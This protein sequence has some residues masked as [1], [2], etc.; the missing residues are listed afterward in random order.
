[1]KKYASLICLLIILSSSISGKNWIGLGVGAGMQ[2]NSEDVKEIY[3]STAFFPYVRMEISLSILK[4]HGLLSRMIF[5][6]DYM[7]A[8]KKSTKEFSVQQLTLKEDFK[9]IQSVLNTGIGIEWDFKG[10][11]YVPYLGVSWFELE[12]FAFEETN[13]I[14]TTGLTFGILLERYISSKKKS[15]L[16]LNIAYSNGKLKEEQKKIG[17]IKIVIGFKVNLNPFRNRFE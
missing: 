14:N 2:M 15:S 7:K 11:K 5:F 9:L 1:M 4:G 3:G 10:I 6:F 8:S 17:G 13:R 16:M 12:E